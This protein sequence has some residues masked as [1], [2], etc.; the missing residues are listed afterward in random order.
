MVL[1]PA[2]MKDPADIF[3]LTQSKRGPAVNIP[4]NGSTPV[5]GK[6]VMGSETPLTSY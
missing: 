3:H 2:N 4:K 5:K 6:Q 1:Y